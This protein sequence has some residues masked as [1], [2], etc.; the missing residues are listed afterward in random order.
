[1]PTFSHSAGTA[2]HDDA[3]PFLTTADGGVIVLDAPVAALWAAAN[4]HTTATLVERFAGEAA[5]QDIVEDTLSCLVHARAL[6]TTSAPPA[7]MS[8]PRASTN[9]P[10]LP[11]VSIIIVVSST[12]ELEFLDECLQSIAESRYQAKQL[13]LVDNASGCDLQATL[14]RYCRRDEG[15]IVDCASR[16][17]LARASN[18]AMNAADGAYAL[19]MN[20][21][22]KVHRDCIAHL[23]ACAGRG[24][25]V[26][27]V[28][29]KTRFWRTPAFINA[30]GN[31]VTPLTWGTD[32]GIGQ[33][34]LGQFDEWTHAPSA[35]LT[36]ELISREAWLDVGPFDERYPA[37]YEDAD[38]AYRARL[39]GWNIRAEPA[40]EAFHIFGG[41]WDT[42]TPGSLSVRKL[43]TAAIGRLR[44]TWKIAGPRLLAKLLKNF[45]I[46]DT[47]NAWIDYRDADGQVARALVRAWAKVTVRLPSLVRDRLRLQRRRAINDDVLFPPERSQPKSYT[48][49]NAPVLTSAIIREEYAPILRRG[50]RG[51]DADSARAADA[52]PG[53]PGSL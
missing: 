11:L 19:L 3:P 16:V 37:Y 52:A 15:K 41:F 5:L 51:R 42:E 25:R 7:T 26:A 2:L 6:T 21:D 9:A 49:R 14:D 46:Q 39:I 53:H 36:I 22:V 13:V 45:L 50:P 10:H 23:V 18:L 43:E 27:A 12:R 28:V 32:N 33:L 38:W 48:C 8:H 30:I 31:R 40:A 4:G 44:W 24:T 29:P 20:P 47:I 1:M 35:S 34:D 17:C